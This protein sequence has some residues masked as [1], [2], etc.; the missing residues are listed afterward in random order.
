MHAPTCRVT[1]AVGWNWRQ[2]PPASV[3]GGRRGADSCAELPGLLWLR[4]RGARDASSRATSRSRRDPRNYEAQLLPAGCLAIRHGRVALPRTPIALTRQSPRVQKALQALQN[5]RCTLTL[6]ALTGH[7]A[8]MT[9]A[10]LYS[11]HDPL[12]IFLHRHDLLFCAWHRNDAAFTCRTPR[13]A[14]GARQE[15][16]PFF[17][18]IIDRRPQ[19]RERR[20]TPAGRGSSADPHSIASIAPPFLPV[21]PL[22]Y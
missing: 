15:A 3:P 20:Q 17:R 19:A 18:R 4:C 8:D 6:A 10:S 11:Q 13:P 16:A 21:Y 9:T 1:K 5:Q 2:A 12:G 14:T 22:Y 7:V